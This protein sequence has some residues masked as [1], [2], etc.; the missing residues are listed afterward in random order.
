MLEQGLAKVRVRYVD[1]RPTRDFSD[2]AEVW[3]RYL[4]DWSF[5][6]PVRTIAST[7]FV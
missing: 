7:R 2:G 1:T 4:R 3:S 6:N 5:W